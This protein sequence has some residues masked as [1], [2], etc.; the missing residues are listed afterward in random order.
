[1]KLPRPK[2]RMKPK[3]QKLLCKCTSQTGGPKSLFSERFLASRSALLLGD[4]GVPWQVYRCP[5]PGV[6][7]WHVSTV[8]W[9]P[10]ASSGSGSGSS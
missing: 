6:R 9:D 4:P 10:W 8:H 5:E 7:G 3:T 2:R 1:M